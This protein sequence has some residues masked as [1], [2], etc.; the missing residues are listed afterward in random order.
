MFPRSNDGTL[1]PGVSF[2][3]G[4]SGT[5]IAFHSQG[6]VALSSDG[7]WLLAVDA[8]SNEITVFRVT[9]T[10]LSMT[11]RVGSMGTMPISVTVRDQW[12]YVLNAVSLNIAG[13][14]LSPSGEL[15][16][17]PGS[18]LPL[19]ALASA[20]EQIGFASSSVGAVLVVTEKGSNQIDTYTVDRTGVPTGPT[21]TPSNGNGPFGFAFNNKGIL[22]DS[23][24]G[25]GA[26]SSYEVSSLGALSV[27]SG[28]VS[29]GGTGDTPCWVAITDNG[30]FAYTGNAN[31]KIS[32]YGIASDGS[33]TLLKENAGTLASGGALDLAFSTGSGYLY[34]LNAAG[35][36]S[37]F[38]VDKSDGGLTLI[39]TAPGVSLSSA[40]L[41]AS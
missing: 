6:A 5:G 15:A 32:S 18:D 37:G 13:F 23:E 20:P 29:T 12:V 17:I 9:P 26:V 7:R 2:S 36:I 38:G 40:G 19:N 31:T 1:G 39:T 4:G 30:R 27:I 10:G 35:S 33:L 25:S 21:T 3:T 16:P 22:V 8:G 34:V 24:A 41:A 14:T 11:D 28:S